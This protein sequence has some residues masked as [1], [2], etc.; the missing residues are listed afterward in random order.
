VAPSLY[1]KKKGGVK[2]FQE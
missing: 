1:P 2:F